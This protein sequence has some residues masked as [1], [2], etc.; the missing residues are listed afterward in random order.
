MQFTRTH[1]R[2]D[3]SLLPPDWTYLEKLKKTSCQ[4]VG[5]G[6]SKDI[7][8]GKVLTQSQHA[9]GK[10]SSML[11]VLELMDMEKEGLIVAN[12][13]VHHRDCGAVFSRLVQPAATVNI[14]NQLF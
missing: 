4:I 11:M 8:L 12:L 6:K 10:N 13:T 3:Y 14:L 2:Q 7:F 9:R 1:D 5:I